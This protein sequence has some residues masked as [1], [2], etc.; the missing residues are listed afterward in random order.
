M[1]LNTDRTARPR[2]RWRLAAIGLG[3]ALVVIVLGAIA[4]ARS[5]GPAGEAGSALGLPS[6]AP[7]VA[8]QAP[9]IGDLPLP[10]QSTA[11]GIY[12]QALDAEDIYYSSEQAAIKAAHAICDYLDAGGSLVSATNVAESDGG[13]SPYE[14]GYI[15]GAAWQALCPGS[16]R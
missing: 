3:T 11:E 2:R 14:A 15:V 10:D 5:D 6:T 7:A 16:V 13:Y 4:G 1:T 9:T 8:P 12:I